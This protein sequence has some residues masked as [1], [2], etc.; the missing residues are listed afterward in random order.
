MYGTP[1]CEEG[2]PCIKNVHDAARELRNIILYDAT[3]NDA[4][5]HGKKKL[6]DLH[7]YCT[8]PDSKKMEFI[9]F[10]EKKERFFQK[11]KTSVPEPVRTKKF[12]EDFP[13]PNHMSF[14]QKANY[15]KTRVPEPVQ[16]KEFPADFPNPNPAKIPRA[17]VPK[18]AKEVKTFAQMAKEVQTSY[19]HGHPY[20]YPAKDPM[21]TDAP[22]NETADQK[23][24]RALFGG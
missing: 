10:Q 14:Q 5:Y 2:F 13:N 3:S 8:G 12:P 21:V 9:D 4:T 11:D 16:R 17:D 18:Q 1:E 20:L 7:I 19:P 6:G 22:R 24:V 15:Y 23:T